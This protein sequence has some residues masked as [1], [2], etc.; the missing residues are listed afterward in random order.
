MYLLKHIAVGEWV[1]G[2]HVHGHGRPSQSHED[3]KQ[4]RSQQRSTAIRRFY[5][6]RTRQG[7]PEL[8]NKHIELV[9]YSAG[10]SDGD[11]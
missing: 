8:D 7:V 3:Q 5:Q 1:D 11:E 9:G 2:R 10:R 4:K 6:L